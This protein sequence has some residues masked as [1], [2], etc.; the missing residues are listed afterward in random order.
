M[1]LGI[2]PV[3]GFPLLFISYG[4]TALL[5]LLLNI[6]IAENVIMCHKRFEF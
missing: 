5:M 2:L 3:V 1:N 6:G 4:S